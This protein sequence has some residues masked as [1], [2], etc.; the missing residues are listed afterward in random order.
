[1]HDYIQWLFPLPERSAF[2]ATAPLLGPADIEA[3][4][5]PTLQ[6]ALG[7]SLARMQSFYRPE[8][9][10]GWL[11]P[12]NHNLLRITRIIRCL[13]VLGQ[14]PAAGSFLDAIL[15]LEGA[16]DIAGPVTLRYWRGA[17]DG[18]AR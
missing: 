3:F 6:A 7:R 18:Q 15:K 14:G 2:N 13:T 4:Q 11:S 8:R 5:S 1:M 12:G 9:R 17:L 10:A 16:A